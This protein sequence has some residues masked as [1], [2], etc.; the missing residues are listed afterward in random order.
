MG[1]AKQEL[2]HRANPLATDIL[3]LAVEKINLFTKG[4]LLGNLVF[5]SF[6][7]FFFFFFFFSFL[8]FAE[9]ILH[10]FR[11]VGADC[12]LPPVGDASQP[13]LGAVLLLLD[14]DGAVKVG[15]E[16]EDVAGSLELPHFEEEAISS[17][18]Q[19]EVEV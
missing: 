7:F 4:R 1:H 2:P 10:L 18:G 5:F 16:S 15:P 13:L 3:H 19:L 12:L 17:S 14:G 9:F 6:F 11:S 8:L